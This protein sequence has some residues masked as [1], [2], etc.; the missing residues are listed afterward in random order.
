[1]TM[2]CNHLNDDGRRTAPVMTVREFADYMKV[3]MP[4]AY[5]LTDKPGF[6]V[7]RVGRKKL[8]IASQLEEWLL[9]E[10][11]GAHAAER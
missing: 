8:V 6:P 2:D 4:T 11:G 5:A 10:V 7:V 1:M 9:G 3:S